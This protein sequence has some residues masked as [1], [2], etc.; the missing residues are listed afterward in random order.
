MLNRQWYLSLAC[1]LI[2]NVIF[3]LVI[4]LYIS[5]VNST[6]NNVN[7]APNSVKSTPNNMLLGFNVV[8]L[9]LVNLSYF[10]TQFLN[11]GI[12]NLAQIQEKEYKRDGKEYCSFCRGFRTSEMEHCPECEVCIEGLDHHCGFFG[13]CIGGWQKIA[14]YTFVI[15]ICAC[16][17]A[18]IFTMSSLVDI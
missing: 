8:M 5:S 6:P 4:G 10:L 11:P 17:F 1:L 2:V 13:K 7:F 16:F 14:F 12:R 3:A 18:M 15:A 9:G